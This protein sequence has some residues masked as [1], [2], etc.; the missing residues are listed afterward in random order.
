MLRSILYAEIITL[1]TETSVLN[2]FGNDNISVDKKYLAG[3]VCAYRR[4]M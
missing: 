1:N 3:V 2:L 4:S